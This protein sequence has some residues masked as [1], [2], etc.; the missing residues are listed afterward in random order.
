MSIV[1][2]ELINSEP[3]GLSVGSKVPFG[4]VAVFLYFALLPLPLNRDLP[5][6]LLALG[7]CMVLSK[8]LP[9][10]GFT[11]HPI[12]IGVFIFLAAVTMSILT[13][14]NISQSLKLSIPFLPAVLLFFVIIYQFKEPH[15]IRMFYIILTFMT[16]AV[17][18]WLLSTVLKAPASS[19]AGW[20]A[21]V[22]SPILVVPNDLTFFSLLAPLSVALIYSE[23][24]GI[25]RL[26]AF[27]SV[28]VSACVACIFQ[29]AVALATTA[30]SLFS[31]FIML[32]PRSI[33]AFSFAS[34][35]LITTLDALFGSPLAAKFVTNWSQRIP[36]WTAA[37]A[38]FRDAPVN[39]HGLNSFGS[40]YISYVRAV[41]LPEWIRVDPRFTPWPH[42]LYLELLAERGIVGLTA[43]LLVLGSGIK[44]ALGSC[45]NG[46]EE[47]AIWAKGALSALLGFSFAA[48]FELS[49]LRLW[50]VVTLFMLLGVLTRISINQTNKESNA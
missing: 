22:N 25:I 48:V 33:P 24:R 37:L 29:S 42:N 39:G 13:S 28:I 41:N 26:L 46:T 5:L 34:L 20:I 32:R 7:S 40:H 9:G 3:C 50:V 21:L 8:I 31:M 38:M 17:S 44:A 12:T 1:S 15:F 16:L 30:V 18:L 4:P 19:P 6:V 35:I 43:L 23:G 49:F 47:T 36:L 14:V 45:K 2:K 11:E 27:F 10:D